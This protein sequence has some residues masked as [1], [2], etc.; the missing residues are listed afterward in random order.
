MYTFLP[1]LTLPYLT[2]FFFSFTTT[3]TTTTTLLI[4]LSILEKKHTNNTNISTDE[5]INTIY[6]FLLFTRHSVC[7]GI[8][9]RFTICLCL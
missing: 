5:T 7:S 9:V 6:A 4:S 8:I 1:Y 3:T 2:P